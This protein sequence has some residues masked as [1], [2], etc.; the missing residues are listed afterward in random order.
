MHAAA[1]L[2]RCMEC[3]RSKWPHASGS[4]HFPSWQLSK[5]WHVSLRGWVAPG[6][7][8]SCYCLRP[9]SICFGLIM[10]ILLHLCRLSLW[11][12]RVQSPCLLKPL[13]L[14]KGLA[15]WA[16]MYAYSLCY[17]VGP[18]WGDRRTVFM[19]AVQHQ[20]W[21]IWHITSMLFID[22]SAFIISDLNQLGFTEWKY[23]AANLYRVLSS[24]AACRMTAQLTV[25]AAVNTVGRTGY[26]CQAQ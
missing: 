1:V 14:S 10:M 12:D 20:V 17:S 7:Y 22:I 11:H 3:V 6:G 4:K 25:P 18:C 9:G 16:A 21:L 26:Y 2:A 24:L 15:L 23:Q 19:I 5:C 13:Q 8:A